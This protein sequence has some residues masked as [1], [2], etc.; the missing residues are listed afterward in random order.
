VQDK[1]RNQQT[2][3]LHILDRNK[4][5]PEAKL[6]LL[7][8]KRVIDTPISLRYSHPDTRIEGCDMLPS[9]KSSFVAATPVES[10][11]RGTEVH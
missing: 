4:C 5:L 9:K 8:H 10:T 2:R 6:N 11:L 1:R 3:N 7:Q